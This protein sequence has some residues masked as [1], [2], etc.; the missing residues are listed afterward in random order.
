MLHFLI[1]GHRF[2]VDKR[3]LGEL[4]GLRDRSG[5]GLRVRDVERRQ[6]VKIRMLDS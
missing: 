5:C 6:C 2:Q 4:G 1:L 3:F